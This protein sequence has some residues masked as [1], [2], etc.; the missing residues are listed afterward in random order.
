[1][2][3]QGIVAYLRAPLLNGDA[4]KR[5][6]N[7][8]TL[9][10]SSSMRSRDGNSILSD[11]AAR[12]AIV[13]NSG[14][15]NTD[16]LASPYVRFYCNIVDDRSCYCRGLI[17]LMGSFVLSELTMM[18]FC[19]VAIRSEES[20]QITRLRIITES[21]LYKAYMESDKTRWPRG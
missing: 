13:E 11:G 10:G 1:M 18:V 7:S 3:K 12:V 20:R 21:V 4:G 5:M 8:L 15:F 9:V 19:W 17:A 14:G 16:A 6:A 2:L